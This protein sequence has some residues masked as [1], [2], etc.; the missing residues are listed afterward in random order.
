MAGENRFREFY[1]LDSRH[2]LSSRRRGRNN[3]RKCGI[4]FAQ[5]GRLKHTPPNAHPFSDDPTPKNNHKLQGETSC[6]TNSFLF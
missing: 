5:R 6:P 4:C 1:I 3:D 2:S